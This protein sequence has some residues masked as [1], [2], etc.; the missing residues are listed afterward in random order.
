[1]NKLL[2]L[3]TFLLFALPIFAQTTTETELYLVSF[4][5][6]KGTDYAISR[7]DAFLRERAM[8]RPP[9]HRPAIT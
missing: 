4:K 5:D 7:P 9:A 6:K 2:L 8:R 3:V 1:M